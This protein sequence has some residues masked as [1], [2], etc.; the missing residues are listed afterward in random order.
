MITLAVA[1]NLSASFAIALLGLKYL[2][3]PV[4]AKYHASILQSWGVPID[5]PHQLLFKAIN[6]I[7]GFVLL[8]LSAGMAAVTYFGILNDDLLWAK[9]LIVVMGLLSGLPIT[10][11]AYS[12]EKET[13]VRT[14]W[15]PS[16]AL[17]G[18]IVFAFGFSLL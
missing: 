17:T 14:P 10:A 18:V 5:A 6:T 9:L 4:P 16:A 7:L 2:F 8:S 3:G 11:V 1:L 13:G 12:M 15:K